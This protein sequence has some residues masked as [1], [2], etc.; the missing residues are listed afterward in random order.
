M[1]N[2]VVFVPDRFAYESNSASWLPKF[3][4][5]CFTSQK[6]KKLGIFV[7]GTELVI[8]CS[9]CILANVFFFLAGISVSVADFGILCLCPFSGGGLDQP[10]R[11]AADAV[12]R[13]PMEDPV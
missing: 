6:K 9:S 10:G 5:L 13:S 3:G 12:V 8:I 4:I 2:S 11:R 1:G 7:L